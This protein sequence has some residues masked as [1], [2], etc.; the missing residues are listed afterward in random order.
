MCLGLREKSVVMGEM[1]SLHNQFDKLT[2]E[3]NNLNVFS[4][5]QLKEGFNVLVKK[6]AC[7]Y[8]EFD[9]SP[10]GLEKEVFDGQL[11]KIPDE[12]EVAD[13]EDQR[14]TSANWL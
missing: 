8:L 1:N 5:W 14:D 12:E 11:V 6:I 7:V 13:D 4:A 3:V 2:G 10:F 9:L